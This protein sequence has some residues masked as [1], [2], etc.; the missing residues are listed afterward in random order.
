MALFDFLKSAPAL[1]A[2]ARSRRDAGDLKGALEDASLVV[3]RLTQSGDKTP[4]LGQGLLV[5]GSVYRSIGRTADAVTALQRAHAQGAAEPA[6][7]TF[8]TGELLRGKGREQSA[9]AIYLA[10]LSLPAGEQ[11]EK[12]TASLRR[13]ASPRGCDK[14]TQDVRRAWNESAAKQ[15][16]QLAWPRAHLGEFALARGDWG[17]AV[18]QLQDAC[19]LAPKDGRSSRLLAYALARAGRLEEALARINLAAQPDPPSLLLRAHL[20]RRLGRPGEALD[21][22]RVS[23][24]GRPVGG[25]ERLALV[26]CLL[27]TNRATQAA[28]VLRTIADKSEPRWLLLAGIAEQ[29]A[30]RAPTALAH[31]RQIIGDAKLGPQAVRRL[32]VL[33]A[34][35]P[36]TEGAAE[37]LA[38]VPAEARSDF[39][40]TVLGNVRLRAN[41]LTGAANAWSKVKQPDQGLLAAWGRA[42]RRLLAERIRAGEDEAVVAIVRGGHVPPALAPAVAAH[43]LGAACRLARR[44]LASGREAAEAFAL[45]LKELETRIR[46]DPTLPA[47][48]GMLLAG[49]GQYAAAWA[50]L[51]DRPQTDGPIAVQRA[52]CALAAA[53]NAPAGLACLRTLPPRD[54]GAARIRAAFEAGRGDWKQ[55]A[56]CL[57][58]VALPASLN[59]PRAAILVQADRGAE[60]TRLPDSPE[61]RFWRASYEARR[62]RT[63]DAAQ[64]LR[65]EATD[66]R[67]QRLL[68]WILWQ[69][70]RKIWQAGRHEIADGLLAE[71]AALWPAEEGGPSASSGRAIAASLRRGR[72]D[73]AAGHLKALAGGGSRS[74]HRLAVFSLSDGEKLARTGDA[75]GAV[76]A[77]EQAIAH[78]G[79]VLSDEAYLRNWLSSRGSAYGATSEDAGV[80]AKVVSFCVAVFNRWATALREK[81][82][83]AAN[84]IRDL[85]LHLR[86]E[87]AGARALRKCATK[88]LGDRLGGLTFLAQERLEET[89]A[90]FLERLEE[91]EEAD[92]DEGPLE[93]LRR[94]M[95]LMSG[96]PDEEQ[97]NG[98]VAE[99][100]ALFSALRV[101]LILQ[102]DGNLQGALERLRSICGNGR[103]NSFGPDRAAFVRGNPAFAGEDGAERMLER[104]RAMEID[105]LCLLGE[106]DVAT[107]GLLD[108]AVKHWQEALAVATTCGQRDAVARRIRD[109]ALGRAQV[110]AK[111]RY[112]EALRVLDL[113]LPLTGDDGQVRGM[114][115][116][117]LARRGVEAAMSQTPRWADSV[118][119]LGRAREMN[120]HSAHVNRNLVM[121]LRGRAQEL[122]A[123]RPS[124]TLR[125]LEEAVAL[126]Q[127]CVASDPHNDQLNELLTRTELELQMVR[128]MAGGLGGLGAHGGGRRQATMHHNRGIELLDAG[129]L[130]GAIR[131]LELA[132]HLEPDSEITRRHLVTASNAL[133]VKLAEANRFD[134]ALAILGRARQLDPL[135]PTVRQNEEAVRS[136]QRF[137][138]LMPRGS[139]ASRLAELMRLM[140]EAE[141]EGR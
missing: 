85:D 65:A 17:G 117:L 106:Q 88:A 80:E 54:A 125:M 98:T 35:H 18:T 71:A 84:R 137:F 38:A 75:K 109:R 46:T 101:P 91:G 11:D 61:V 131:E 108:S 57:D 141:D 82:A 133:G 122:F 72:R 5:Q 110:L 7:L 119:D 14:S 102:R 87:L 73:G 97:E 13:W 25:E 9:G 104:A 74:C 56:A 1:L 69:Q 126:A 134:E 37:A 16:P 138:A 96:E 58:G 120:P 100:E 48:R 50:I 20:L 34:R 3:E 124:E 123:D 89:F 36:D 43:V 19:R 99:L 39:Y 51:K 31:Y 90:D 115:S 94:M 79:V 62:G 105:L 139:A 26:E 129:D 107:E 41:S 33:L 64:L 76:A 49:L 114:L 4:L 30:G 23:L 77:W 21:D 111:N 6:L 112:E 2:R 127:E 86:A 81:D 52:R 113:C 8:L 10:Y 45:V 27:N 128:L 70:G 59:G 121:A 92:E 103:V 67:A 28:S 29:A 60:L 47:V 132:L 140:K 116:A 44:T 55:A 83:A 118:S 130:E 135:D 136:A 32:L 24:A 93:A 68:G 66:R 15:C 53:L 63:A 78:V 12:V 22:Y 95:R 40:W 42:L